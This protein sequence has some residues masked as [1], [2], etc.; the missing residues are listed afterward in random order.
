LRA[1]KTSDGGKYFSTKFLG[2]A[3]LGE[4][5]RIVLRERCVQVLAMSGSSTP[6]GVNGTVLMRRN[7]L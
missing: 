3:S 6:R 1:R 2:F 4:Q 5:R 7:L